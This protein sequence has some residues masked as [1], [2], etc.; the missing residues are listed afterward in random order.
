MTCLSNQSVNWL[1][2]KYIYCT[3]PLILPCWSPYF[4]LIHTPYFLLRKKKKERKKKKTSFIEILLYFS[5]NI[6]VN[7]IRQS[8]NVHVLATLY[9]VSYI[10]SNI[11][12]WSC[13]RFDFIVVA[14][15]NPL[16][17]RMDHSNKTT[18][19]R[20]FKKKKILYLQSQ[21]FHQGF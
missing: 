18:Y 8:R 5:F 12:H 15:T 11:Y 20:K 6:V 16:N 21:S 4:V 1:W 19:K 7:P 10:F 14:W 2:P 17:N 13:M 9:L 3:S